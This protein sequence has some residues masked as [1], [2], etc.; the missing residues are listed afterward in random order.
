MRVT[1]KATFAVVMITSGRRPAVCFRKVVHEVFRIVQ[2]L[3]QIHQEDLI[4]RPEGPPAD[5]G[6]AAERIV[7][8]FSASSLAAKSMAVTRQPRRSIRLRRS[9]GRFRVAGL[10]AGGARFDCKSLR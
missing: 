3:D 4:V 9:H 8:G 7:S 5:C 2:M 1:K 10:L 6:L